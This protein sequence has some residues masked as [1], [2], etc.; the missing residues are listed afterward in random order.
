[1][2]PRTGAQHICARTRRVRRYLY[3]RRRGQFG[4]MGHRR[5]SG[6]TKCPTDHMLAWSPGDRAA[7][8]LLLAI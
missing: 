3:V 1:M 8:R 6:R 4:Q 7:V 2:T 5:T